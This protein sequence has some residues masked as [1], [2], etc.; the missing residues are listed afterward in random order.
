MPPS[1]PSLDPVLIDTDPGLGLPFCDVD[2]ALAIQ[3]LVAAG[4]PVAG[5]TTCFGNSGLA[6][7]HAVAERLGERWGLPVSR[8]A[9][10]PGDADTPATDALLAH[11][12]TVLALAPL[13][14]VAAALRRGARWSRL[15]VLG[16]T[17]RRTP[18]LRPLH[19]TELNFALDLDAAAAVLPHTDALFPME[20]CRT[21]WC[22]RRELDRLPA[23][24]GRQCRGWLRIAPLMTGRR[25]FHPWDVLP[26]LYL[27][28]PDLY[29]T[30]AYS[31][32]LDTAPLYRGRVRYAPGATA[33]ATRVQ[34]GAFLE[35]W[36]SLAGGPDSSQSP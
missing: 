16:G 17:D 25:A 12:G 4:A 7:T 5:L 10:R 27:L 18:N 20:I 19:T 2:D 23:W 36:L 1:P 21:V 32:T 24:L 15:V 8:G 9:A 26:A 35:A 33:V 14:N 6:R 3:L 22:G 28:R 11:R 29:A 30:L 13:T 34:P 31:V